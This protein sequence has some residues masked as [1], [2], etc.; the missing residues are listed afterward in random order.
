MLH[1]ASISLKNLK[2]FMHPIRHHWMTI[3]LCALRAAVL[4]YR[5]P[6]SPAPW[7]DEGLNVRRHRP[8][9]WRCGAVEQRSS[10]NGRF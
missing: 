9:M 5:Q 10:R 3:A 1:Q 6:I 7:F 4:L 2:Q 8:V